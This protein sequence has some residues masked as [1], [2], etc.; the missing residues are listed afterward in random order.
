M[1]RT[2]F[3]G[4]GLLVFTMACGSN[5]PEADNGPMQDYPPITEPLIEGTA[6]RYELKEQTIPAGNDVVLCHFLEKT[7]EEMFVT[8]FEAMQGRHGHHLIIFK[9]RVPEAPG[10]VRE[11]ST[12]QDMVRFTPVISSVQFGLEK[13]PDGMAIRVPVG[14]QIVIQQHYVNTSTRDINVKDI[15]FM[16]VVPKEEVQVLAGFFGLSDVFL[17]LPPKQATSLIFD[18]PVPFDMNILLVG[19][20]MH[21]WGTNFKATL[22]RPTGSEELID[23]EWHADYRDEP[24]VESWEMNEPLVMHEG[25]IIRTRCDFMND[26]DQPIKFPKEMCATYGYFFPAQPERDEFLCAG[27]QPE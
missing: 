14:S 5:E 3:S 8:A 16:H 7:T 26:L 12:P 11:C 10:T 22:E 23:V 6:I 1:K 13:F 27:S 20:H 2:I 18:C 24:P 9:A 15:G 19:P 25:D 17:D 4:A 21:E